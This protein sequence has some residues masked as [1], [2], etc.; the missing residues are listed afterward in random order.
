MPGAASRDAVP[1]SRWATIHFVRNGDRVWMFNERGELIIARL[2][3]K[4]YEEISRGRVIRPTSKP[5][6]L[7]EFDA[8]VW[9]HPAFANGHM[10]VRNDEE[11]VRVRLAGGR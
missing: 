7:R 10:I 11:I 5:G 4:G 2:T 1:R 6:A 8:V 3:P 9:T